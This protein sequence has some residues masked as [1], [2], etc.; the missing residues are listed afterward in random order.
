MK[1]IGITGPAGSGKDSVAIELVAKFSFQSY[2]FAA[3]LKR[4]LS[5]MFGIPEYEFYD[6]DIKEQIIPWMGMSRRKLMQIAGT[7]F[8]RNMIADDIWLRLADRFIENE[9]KVHEDLLLQT[10]R[11]ETELRIVISDVRFEN[12]AEWVRDK[13]GEVWHVHRLHT[14]PVE[15]HSS[16]AGVEFNIDKD[17]IIRNNGSLSDLRQTVHDMIML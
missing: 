12:E 6:R 5:A 14:V 3:P 11:A 17:V 9:I 16:E 1:L 13:G 10:F 15:L 7:E 4:G 8:A 2:S